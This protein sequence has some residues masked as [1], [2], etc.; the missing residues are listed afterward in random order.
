MRTIN[1]RTREGAEQAILAII[2]AAGGEFC[3]TIFWITANQKRACAAQ[4]L[5]DGERIHADNSRG[6]PTII[7]TRMTPS[8]TGKGRQDTRLS[9]SS[10]ASDAAYVSA[11]GGV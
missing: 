1:G 6:Y 7:L 8:P 10:P 2:D 3:T 9:P 4:R 11:G 5:V